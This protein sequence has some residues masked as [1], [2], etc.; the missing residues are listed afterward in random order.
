MLTGIGHLQMHV[1]DLAAC[2]ALYGE[3]LG[4]TEIAHGEG[5][6][7]DQL[8]M[9]CI[10]DS[11]LELHEDAHAVAEMQPSGEKKPR[12]DVP[13]SIEHFAFYADDNNEVYAL[14]QETMGDKPH[15]TTRSGPEV[16]TLGHAYIQRSLLQFDDPDGYIIQIAELVDPRA[17]VQAR[18]AEKTAAAAA[19][20]DL[21]RGIDHIQIICA[22]L[23]S[24]RN[25]LGDILGLEE[26]NYRNVTV[27]A[28]EGFEESTFA[29]G[30]TE[31]EVSR[32]ALTAGRKLGPGAVTS[33]G[34]WTSDLEETRKLML[35]KGLTV[36][37]PL[38][39]SPLAG[40]R[41]RA[42]EIEGLDGLRM[43]VAQRL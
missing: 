30:L 38:L 41:R 14:L 26:V 40:V 35:G 7:G 5:P 33:L 37:E 19:A 42:I 9:F 1:R 2:R 8:S 12:L 43:E 22:N 13:G 24:A 11:I 31:L 17:E 4:L 23:D 18:I 21:L 25:L 36:S 39:L 20:A 29:I 28:I 34:F 10:G 15:F 6:D 16:Q 32:S 27:P 3:Q